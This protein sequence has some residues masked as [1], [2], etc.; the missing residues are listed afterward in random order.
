MKIVVCVKLIP[1]PTGPQE[2]DEHFNLKRT[3]KLVLDEADTYGVEIALRL[4]EASGTGEVVVVSMGP[5]GDLSGLRSA[6]AMGASRGVIVDDDSLR[7]VDS[8]GTAKVLAAVISKESPDLI[9]CA[10]E[11][12]D[13]Y[14]GV[15]P[16]Q[17]AEILGVPSLTYA[18]SVHVGPSGV[19]INRQT[20][21]GHLE[22]VAKLPCVVTVTAGAVEPR[23]ASFKGIMA[24]KSKPIEVL[25]VGDLSFVNGNG[26]VKAGQEVYATVAGESRAAGQ[27]FVDDG[28]G[29]ERIVAYLDSLKVL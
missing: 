20:S 6:L 13:G 7:G 25:N 11:S 19:T 23:Y 17:I 15:V 5:S 16:V 8:L 29:A 12:S 21:S 1:D 10:T 26:S 14:C 3:G 2:F 4:V 24:S 18:N 9:F 22:V 28:D 27:K